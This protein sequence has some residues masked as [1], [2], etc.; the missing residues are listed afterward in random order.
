MRSDK[1]SRVLGSPDE[2]AHGLVWLFKMTANRPLRLVS[3]GQTG[4]D[5]AA[6]DVARRLG[7]PFGGWCP[8]GRRTEAGPLPRRYRLRET[9]SRDYAQRTRWNVRDSDGILIINRGAFDG[10]TKLTERLARETFGKPVYIQQTE[11]KLVPGHF[12][13]W[14]ARHR[15]RILNVAGPRESKRSGIQ[16]EASKFLATLLSVDRLPLGSQSQLSQT[17]HRVGPLRRNS[18]EVNDREF[19]WT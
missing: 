15:I 10:G 3:G 17:A 12:A 2:P 5:R 9:P 7:M 11:K 8:R 18:R 19:A 14:L 13:A 1:D 4:V 6:L 16:A